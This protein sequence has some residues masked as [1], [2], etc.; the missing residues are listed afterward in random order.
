MRIR[1]Y[2]CVNWYFLAY[3][4]LADVCFESPSPTNC[5]IKCMYDQSP[6]VMS[7][8]THNKLMSLTHFGVLRAMAL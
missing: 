4:Y 7:V 5:E 8:K 1:M 2:V 3:I 6:C